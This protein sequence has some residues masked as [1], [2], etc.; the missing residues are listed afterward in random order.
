MLQCKCQKEDQKEVLA[1]KKFMLK[2]SGM[3]AAFALVITTVVANSA[4]V[5]ITHQE[6]L[7]ESAKALRKF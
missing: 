4:C 1:L 6:Q 3:L 7:P 2:Y 5:W